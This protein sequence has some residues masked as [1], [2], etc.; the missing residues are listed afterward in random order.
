MMTVQDTQD[1]RPNC[2]DKRSWTSVHTPIFDPT[3]GT[4]ADRMAYCTQRK[5][6]GYFFVGGDQRDAQGAIT[7]NDTALLGSS[8]IH[9]N[10]CFAPP[11]ESRVPRLWGLMYVSY[12]KLKVMIGKDYWGPLLR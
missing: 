7:G 3:T 10:A 8:I 4:T 5:T 12:S 6:L 11:W 9:V 2:G 1:Q